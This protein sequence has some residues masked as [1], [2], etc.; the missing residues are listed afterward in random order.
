MAGWCTCALGVKKL[1][2]IG[3][4]IIGLT[5]DP[6]D[7]SYG[8]AGTFV[9]RANNIQNGK[10]TPEDAVYVTSDIPEKLKLI[11]H[12]I[13]ICSRNGSRHLIGKCGL[14]TDEF[15]GCT[16]GA[17]NTVFRSQANYFI[18]YVLNSSLFEFQSG[19]YLTATINQLTV[20][21]LNSFLVPL[22]PPSEQSRIVASLDSAEIRFESMFAHVE[23]AIARLREYRTA[24]ITAATTGKIDVRNVASPAPT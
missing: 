13:L 5:Y 16:F 14:V 2:F 23:T 17:F 9:L 3:D 18:Y 22:P 7:I 20:S 15:V 19:S 24:L 8:Q 1:K 21:T 12:D 11:A 4:A 10:L 6:N